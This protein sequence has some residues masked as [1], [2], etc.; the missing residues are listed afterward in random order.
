MI[1]LSVRTIPSLALLTFLAIASPGHAARLPQFLCDIYRDTFI[2]LGC[3]QT[4]NLF[5][6]IINGLLTDTLFGRPACDYFPCRLYGRNV[7]LCRVPQR[8]L[9]SERNGI[10]NRG[11]VCCTALRQSSSSASSS[12]GSQSF[13]LDNPDNNNNMDPGAF[14]VEDVPA[15]FQDNNGTELYQKEDD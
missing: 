6:N 5:C 9:R 8:C 11:E 13:A 14:A 3:V 7:G 15:F 1:G 12:S 2:N 10:C 4:E